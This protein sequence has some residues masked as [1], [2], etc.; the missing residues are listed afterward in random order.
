[1]EQSVSTLLNCSENNDFFKWT[2]LLIIRFSSSDIRHFL[3][4]STYIPRIFYGFSTGFLW[5]FSAF[6]RVVPVE[7]P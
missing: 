3:V 2:Q 1:M 7:D 5:V 4:P 6:L